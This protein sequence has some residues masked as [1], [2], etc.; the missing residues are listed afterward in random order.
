[1]SPGPRRS[2]RDNAVAVATSQVVARGLGLVATILVTRA[3]PVGDFGRYTAALALAALLAPLAD[4]GTDVHLTRT[5]ARDPGSAAR[6]LGASLALKVGLAALFVLA[7]W[8]AA[9]VWLDPAIV[10]LAV[11]AALAVAANAFAGSFGAVVRGLQRMDRDALALI[12]ARLAH[13]A[14]TIGAVV[15]GAGALGILSWQAAAMTAAIAIAVVTAAGVAP[16]P[17]FDGASRGALALLRGGAPFAGTA[18]LVTLYFRL[19]VLMLARMRGEHST[20]LYGACAQLLFA[21]LLVSQALVTAVFPVVSAAGTLATDAV[22]RVVA[23][24]AALS[25]AA[26]LPFPI[27]ASFLAAPL[28]E[29]LYG[30]AYA[31]AAPALVVLAWTTPV[32]FLTNLLGHVLGALG[33][34]HRVLAISA[35]NAGFNVAL[36]LW[37]IPIWDFT[38]AA[39]ATLATELVG[40]AG[41]ALLLR[42]SLGALLPWRTLAGVGA[43]GAALALVLAAAH[44]GFW[45]APLALVLGA[46]AYLAVLVAAGIVRREDL[47][48]LSSKP[49]N[50]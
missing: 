44:R 33:R 24:A 13:V 20:A 4:L 18:L 21:T 27:A 26:S 42:G 16:A 3:L 37:L 40:L 35:V 9:V 25:L 39:L 29:L 41:F 12:G 7:V 1:M 19:D 17:R 34:Q 49:K 8:G 11:V 46:V 23:R 6:G 30:G 22:R 45:P 10:P 38:G 47:A 43:A 31:A 48:V 14:A 50:P 36:N 15:A 28:L 5:V 32:L 2:V